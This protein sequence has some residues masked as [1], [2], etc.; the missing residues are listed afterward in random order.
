MQ[1][2]TVQPSRSANLSWPFIILMMTLL[3]MWGLLVSM[4]W[5]A[6]WMVLVGCALVPLILVSLRHTQFMVAATLF[7]LFSNAP[8]VAVRFHG[9]PTALALIVPPAALLFVWLFQLVVRREPFVFPRAWPWAL[10]FLAVEV[11][12][13]MFCRYP[14]AARNILQTHIIEGLG[15]FL[16]VC[17]VVRTRNCL[18]QIVVALLLAGALLGGLSLWQQVTAT[19]GNDYGGFAQVPMEG[20]GLEIV[21]P[22]RQRRAAGSLGEKNRY[23]QN[24][25]MLVPLAVLPMSSARGWR[26]TGY[27]VAALLIAA[28][29]I[30][31]FSRGAAV[32]FVMLL[33]IMKGMGYIRMRH[34][35]MLTLAAV[36][37]LLAFP[38]LTRRMD[39]VGTLIGYVRGDKAAQA[40]E[41][42]G[43]ITGRATSML[44]ALRVT[45]DYP[46]L[47]VGPGNFRLYNREYS[48][49]GGF[50][51]HAE[52]RQAHSLYLHL[53]AE[54]GLLG[55]GIFMAMVGTTLLG[56]HRVWSVNRHSDPVMS[57][58]A[59][60]FA[61]A[62]LA[63]LLTG[64]FLHFSYIRF[65]WL[66]LALACCVPL[67]ADRESR[68][69]HAKL[70]LRWIG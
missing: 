4:R 49:V 47:G 3:V 41:L 28:G 26:K 48:K 55:L 31:T 32:A 63:Y 22:Q 8:V 45:A 14:D 62:I 39:S 37:F 18:Q 6:G 9:V 1:I 43:A 46:V 23:A 30:L 24:L 58:L 11:I 29:C 35:I 52:D 42:D 7:L 25:L 60:G 16:I 66:F 2:T 5:G 57:G 65:F 67:I 70:P 40:E 17:N 34:L 50:K 19:H 10:A 20:E 15:L 68:D 13:A 69:S 56:L 33:L 38:Q 21:D 36:L 44:A 12:S 64:L 61:M 53:A 51:A 54:A 27:F 59:A